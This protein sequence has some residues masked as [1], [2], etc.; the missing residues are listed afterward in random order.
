MNILITGATSGIGQALA[1]HY[2]AQANSQ[3]H[4]FVIGRSQK[5]LS[6]LEDNGAIPLACDLTQ[7]QAVLNLAADISK[8]VE[9]LDLVILNAGN[10]I[11][12]EP[13]HNDNAANSLSSVLVKNIESNL[14][15]MAYAIDLVLPFLTQSTSRTQASKLVLMGSLASDFPF[16][17]SQG[18]GSSKAAVAYLAKSL[19][20]DYPQINV[21]LVQ[22][23]FVKTPLTDKNEFKM[24]ALVSTEQAAD[25]I[26]SGIENNKS[27][28][29]FPTIF[30]FIIKCL[31]AFPL[32]LQLYIAKK[33]KQ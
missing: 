23:G 3:D 6:L 25:A 5:K 1:L 12:Y 29:R 10:C 20:V 33:M 31:G 32:S 27:L 15:T 13:E 26:V 19:Q 18:Y 7:K 9:H 22:P 21:S 8:R 4:V 16:T 2:L 28:I 17:K 24:P 30:S 14:F 11:Y